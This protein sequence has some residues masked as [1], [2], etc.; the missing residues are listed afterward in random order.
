MTGF[1][2][3]PRSESAT[4]AEQIMSKSPKSF[5]D[6]SNGVVL[7]QGYE[8]V[9]TQLKNHVYNISRGKSGELRKNYSPL[10]KMIPTESVIMF[11]L[12]N[13]YGCVSGAWQPC[14]YP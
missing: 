5:R 12:Q 9:F 1:K 7:G 10:V 2:K 3:S 14:A 13:S 8:S 6:E 4:I 11:H